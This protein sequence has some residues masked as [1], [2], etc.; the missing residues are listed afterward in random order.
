MIDS[1]L[2]QRQFKSG[3]YG[4][5]YRSSGDHADRHCAIALPQLSHSNDAYGHRARPDRV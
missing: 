5:E 3:E 2:P 4:T 1:F